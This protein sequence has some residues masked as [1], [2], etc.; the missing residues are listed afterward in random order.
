MWQEVK[1]RVTAS[2]PRHLQMRRV[3]LLL[4]PLLLLLSARL[5]SMAA[6][7]VTIACRPGRKR[8]KFPYKFARLHVLQSV[9]I[10]YVR[11]SWQVLACGIT[12]GTTS[13]AFPDD[14]ARLQ[15]FVYP[16]IVAL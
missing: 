2:D 3:F 10:R 13:P 1:G 9:S 14:S 15:M 5:H 7:Q 4:P 16:V 12:K 8:Q 11:G 6:L